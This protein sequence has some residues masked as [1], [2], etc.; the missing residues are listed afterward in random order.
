LIGRMLAEATHLLELVKLGLRPVGVLHHVSPQ[1]AVIARL[2]RVLG[3]DFVVSLL[4][5]H[6]RNWPEVTSMST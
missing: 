3:V 5:I 4:S 1:G 2:H 6:L